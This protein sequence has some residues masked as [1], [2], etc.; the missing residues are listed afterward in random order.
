M[1][2]WYFANLLVHRSPRP[3]IQKK[4]SFSSRHASQFT[5]RRQS[6]PNVWD[7]PK[8]KKP[9]FGGADAEDD[10]LKEGEVV[11]SPRGRRRS[12]AGNKDDK[13]RGTSNGSYKYP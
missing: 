1:M 5:K 12:S 10:I 3:T 13:K 9:S 6:A 4:S 11:A 8:M 2:L 7:P